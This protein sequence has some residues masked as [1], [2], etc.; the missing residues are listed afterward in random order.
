MQSNADHSIR[1][2]PVWGRGN[3]DPATYHGPRLTAERGAYLN[4]TTQRYSDGIERPV[5]ITCTCNKVQ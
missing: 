1:F 3:A 5:Q 4:V 2:V